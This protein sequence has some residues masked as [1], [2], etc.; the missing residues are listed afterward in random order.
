MSFLPSST[1]VFLCLALTDMHKSIDKLVAP[2]KEVIGSDPLGENLQVFRNRAED[3]FKVLF[4][5]RSGF[6]ITTSA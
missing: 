1:R 2:A 5:D 4:W 6:A 3:R